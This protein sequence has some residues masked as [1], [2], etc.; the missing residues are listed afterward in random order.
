LPVALMTSVQ[1]ACCAG[2]PNQ[3]PPPPPDMLASR[4]RWTATLTTCVVD[5]HSASRAHTNTPANPLCHKAQTLRKKTE[6]LFP[7]PLVLVLLWGVKTGALANAVQ[8]VPRNSIHRQ[9]AAAVFFCFLPTHNMPQGAARAWKNSYASMH[10]PHPAHT[11]HPPCC[12]TRAAKST[13]VPPS[14]PWE[15]TQGD[16]SAK[17]PLLGR[18]PGV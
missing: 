5:T 15:H 2:P 8:D 11:T 16:Y 1:G 10:H 17:F 14:S 4:R 3:R 12:S 9:T 7:S 13:A 6:R 18:R